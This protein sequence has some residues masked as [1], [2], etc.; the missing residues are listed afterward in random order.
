MP[1]LVGHWNPD[2]NIWNDLE[3][4]DTKDDMLGTM[5]HSQDKDL[6]KAET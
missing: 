5:T 3:T 1:G 4:D 2:L 6:V